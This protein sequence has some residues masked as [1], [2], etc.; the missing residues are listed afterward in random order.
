VSFPFAA[1]HVAFVLIAWPWADSRRQDYTR[2]LFLGGFANWTAPAVGLAAE[3]P[4]DGKDLEY[5]CLPV[6]L[7]PSNG[8]RGQYPKVIYPP[9]YTIIVAPFCSAFY[10]LA[11]D[12]EIILRSADCSI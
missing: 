3:T 4:D 7:K 1:A 5:T 10:G 2:L 6:C 9:H 12:R 8:R 11:D